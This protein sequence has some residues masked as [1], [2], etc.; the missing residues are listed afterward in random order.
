[1][2]KR[3]TF[4]LRALWIAL[5]VFN[6]T[7]LTAQSSKVT[8]ENNWGKQGISLKTQGENGLVINSSINAYSVSE[9]MVDNNPMQTITTGG[10][11][12]QNNEGA[13]NI[14]SFSNYIAVPQGAT[15]SAK[16]VR[17][18]TTQVE[19]IIIAPAP[20]I[21]KDNEN[22]PLVFNKDP[23]IY[24][25]NQFYPN[26][27]VK[28]SS[29][30]KIRGM[31]VVIVGISPFQY[32]P[33]TNQM[34][35]HRDIEIEITFEGGNGQFGED[36]LRSRWWD[37]IMRDAI[38]N[39]SSIEEVNTSMRGTNETGFE[40]VIIVP[41]DAT[42]ISW[43][44]SL[45]NFRIRQGITTNV[46]TTTEVGGNTVSAIEGWVNNAY[47]TWDI[48]PAAVLLMADYGTSGNTIISPIYNNY[49]VSDNIFGDVDGDHMPEVIF[50]RMT[51]QNEGHLETFVTKVLN[52]ER[53]PPVNPDFYNNPITA[54]G[55]QTER[56]FQI[57]SET[58]GGFLKNV[59]GKDPVRINAIYG[60]NPAVDPWST[61]TN[62]AT[63]LNYFGPNGLG[64]IPA[65]P[66]EL[67]GWSGGNATE[68]NNAINSGAFILQHRD[69]G[70]TTGWG[71][72]DY[73]N[74][75]INGLTNTDLT[76]IFS[77]NCL[78]GM[79]NSPSE[80]FAEKFHRYKY[81]GQ[82]SGAL[83]IIAASEVSY[84]FVNDTYVW[85]LYDNMWPE[86]MPDYGT[87]PDS[88]GILPAFGNAAG[89]YFLQ[90]SS[91]PYN[92]NN[93][94]VTYNL[95]HHHGDAFSVVY[96]EVPQYLTVSHEVGLIAGE[97][98]FEVSADADSFIA[99]TVNNEIIGTA[100]GTG[101]PVSI[102]IVAQM[103]PD[104]ILVTVTKQNYYRYESFVDVIPPDGPYVI[105]NDFIINDV[106]GNSNGIMECGE[107]TLTT[108]TMKNIGVEEGVD[109]SVNI[110]TSD[111]YIVLTDD[112]EDYGNVPAGATSAIPDGF[113]WEVAN[114]IPD[115]HNVVFAIEAT[116]GTDIWTSTMSVTG[117]APLL[118]IGQ[119]NIDDS[120][121]GNGNGNLDPGETIDLII[122]NYNDG[123]YVAL[124]SFGSLITTSPFITLNSSE[125]DIG[126]IES[127]TMAT[128]TFNITVAD[129]TPL[130]SL[131]EFIYHL[132]SGGY[133]AETIFS[134][135][136]GLIIEDWETGDMSQFEWQTGGNNN[137]FVSTSNPYEGT[138]CNQSGPITDQQ[139]TWMTLIYD[140]YTADSISFYAMVSSEQAYDFFRFYI[141]GVLKV[142][143][144]GEMP[145]QRVSFPVSAG[146]RTFRWQYSKDY[147]VTNG[148]DCARVDYIV[149]PLPP[150]T[151]AFAGMDANFCETDEIQCQGIVS[152]CDS[153]L[154]ITSGTGIFDD[155]H[156]LTPIYMPSAEDIEAGAVML[157]LT[158]YGPE[159]TVSDD[160]NFTI[161]KAPS[162]Y[163]GET[164][165]VCSNE[166]YFIAD[167][168]AEN[169]NSLEWTTLGDGTFDDAGI[170]NPNYSPGPTDI[171]NGVTSLILTV[172]GAEACEPISD[173]LELIVHSA[174]TAF[175]GIDADI[176]SMLTYTINDASALNYEEILWT[177]TGDGTFD[178]ANSENPTYIPGE[179][180]KIIKEVT[181]TL[182]A[183]SGNICPTV[184][185]DMLLTLYCTD[186]SDL[187]SQGRIS[188]YPNPN[189]G[190]FT[191]KLENIAN[192]NADIRI[193]NSLGKV[194]Y[195][196]SNVQ[197]SNNFIN[198]IDLDV[199]P[200]SY[201]IK[202][203]GI[204]TNINSK[205]II[206]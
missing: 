36:R 199:L 198:D 104:Q 103:P 188:L 109:I 175:A 106:N 161:G 84:S 180:D 88:R 105:Y 136:A 151:S 41:D 204:I 141:D 74:N 46:F 166:S 146:T 53:T 89:K 80:C 72:P 182:T 126:D 162:S 11:Y 178:D 54:L 42:F 131:I 173:Q 40:Y 174:T 194:V 124:S 85:G 120:E 55:W 86:F 190:K 26:D 197:L 118:S 127:D 47:N 45:K 130:G 193:F 18:Q 157:T 52:Y 79:Y 9:T 91:W 185:D 144:S 39:Q 70:G 121:H 155:D 19:N 22:G 150:I 38:L 177:S 149:L 30:S 57:C 29:P 37:P 33:V 51:A 111:P 140:V 81:N 191:L 152:Y 100:V 67:G 195:E 101:S 44:D 201:T 184:I 62:T 95:F 148:E 32:N 98:S 71:E 14:P 133:E 21:P 10:V 163:S 202:I 165:S 117:H 24:S 56:W 1:M 96:S 158:G 200:G 58:V 17:K 196:K 50:A 99:L 129:G 187:S 119:M 159:N 87:T 92:T 35:I 137:W 20:I 97:T 205:F 73:S 139:S 145:W 59:H 114:N 160:V 27:I 107:S 143:W 156:I 167:A 12:L 123:S 16:V 192:E 172:I 83:G 112:I 82:N 43:A 116:D 134:K 94:E 76:F 147:S 168:M 142:N 13:P 63:V 153:T 68:V 31:D 48:P 179:N 23:K 108:I 77:I 6:I 25:K 135:P 66:A 2:K 125:F 164:G 181:L 60:G 49:C 206:K 90:Q 102:S 132:E 186:I 93:K 128:A 122:D 170:V 171:E 78:T 138:Y 75:N 69:H 203:E 176:C 4:F 7:G 154:W 110:A 183:T 3:I 34:I 28:I 64:Y 15:V 169:Y 61:A 115:M 8:Y 113:A 65:T 5:L 189:N